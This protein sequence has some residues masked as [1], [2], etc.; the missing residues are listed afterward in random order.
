[1]FDKAADG[2]R[3]VQQMKTSTVQAPPEK[4]TMRNV[5]GWACAGLARSA[6]GTGGLRTG[7][8]CPTRTTRSRSYNRAMTLQ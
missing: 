6:L 1:M 3:P 7:Y 2:A 5:S 4:T 8:A